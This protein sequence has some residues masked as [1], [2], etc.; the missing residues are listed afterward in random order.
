MALMSLNYKLDMKED[1]VSYVCFLIGSV[2][3]KMLLCE[4]GSFRFVLTD[5]SVC[6]LVYLMYKKT[7]L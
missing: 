4:C 1:L 6:A 3:G 7:L 5:N 2:M